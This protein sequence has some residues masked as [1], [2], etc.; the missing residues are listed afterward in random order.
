MPEASRFEEDVDYLDSIGWPTLRDEALTLSISAH[1]WIGWSLGGATIPD[2][3]SMFCV[4]C[5]TVR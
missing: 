3:E 1:D 4:Q 2:A 5:S